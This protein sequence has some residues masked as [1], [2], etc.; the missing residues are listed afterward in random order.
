[1]NIGGPVGSHRIIFMEF[2]CLIFLCCVFRPSVYGDIRQVM[3]STGKT[4]SQCLK[5]MVKRTR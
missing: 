4:I 5:W 1:M 2:H 3:K